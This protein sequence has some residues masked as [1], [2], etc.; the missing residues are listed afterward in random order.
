MK[1]FLEFL[2]SFFQGKPE[3]AKS[4]LKKLDPERLRRERIKSEQAEAQINKE[5]EELEAQKDECFAQGVASS[6]DRQKSQYAR[7]IKQLETQIK[8]HERHLSLINR[9]IRVISGV[10]QIKENEQ[11]LTKLGMDNIVN[12]MD[13]AELHQWVEEATVEGRFQMEKFEEVLGALAGAEAVYEFEDPDDA[14]T[15]ALVDAMNEAA[16][17][18]NLDEAK[19][20][21][22]EVENSVKSEDSP[23]VT[24]GV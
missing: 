18:K 23:N 17:L 4:T 15:Q 11:L 3:K 24:Q 19:S 8:S 22:L 20:L 9:N 10:T 13:L 16:E 2:L 21:Q 7:K 5:I 1:R 6:S 12:Q 14:E